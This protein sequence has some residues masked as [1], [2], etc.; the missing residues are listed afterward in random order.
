M[1]GDSGF[2]RTPRMSE[3]KALQL[4]IAYVEGGGRGWRKLAVKSDGAL[5]SRKYL[6]YDEVWWMIGLE[7][8]RLPGHAEGIALDSAAYDWFQV[9][10]D[11]VVEPWGPESRNA[12]APGNETAPRE[13]S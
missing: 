11:G 3:A 10:P 13:E 7:F 4:T 12:C 5:T 8:E 1:L 6:M 2:S 9:S